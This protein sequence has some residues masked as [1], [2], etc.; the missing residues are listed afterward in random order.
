MA[1]DYDPI[2][3]RRGGWRPTPVGCDSVVGRA[4]RARLQRVRRN[5][6]PDKRL[7]DRVG[8]RQGEVGALAAVRPRRLLDLAGMADDA[9]P[10][11]R[12]RLC[13]SMHVAQ[14]GAIAVGHGRRIAGE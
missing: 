10:D 5:A 13:T 14:D 6:H 9:Q 8:A 1:A 7:G 4:A 12:A 3:R 11:C 2:R